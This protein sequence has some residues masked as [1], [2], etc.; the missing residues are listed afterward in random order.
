MEN[1]LS[2]GS[3]MIILFIV[4]C[5]VLVGWSFTIGF[6]GIDRAI[7]AIDS[8]VQPSQA[9]ADE[10]MI[11]I[12]AG[13]SV[14]IGDYTVR[15]KTIR[16]YGR[17]V[18][19]SNGVWVETMT[20]TGCITSIIVQCESS[21]GKSALCPDA[22][23]NTPILIDLESMTPYGGSMGKPSNPS[24]PVTLDTKGRLGRVARLAYVFDLPERVN[25]DQS[26][27]LLLSGG[28]SQTP[29][30]YVFYLQ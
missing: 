1:K 23:L 26:Y 30:T 27:A 19:F 8:V 12:Q 17:Y 16:N 7:P 13:E 9:D 20:S 4:A 15:A 24:T 5:L 28:D 2:F 18:M 25:K 22:L 6:P 3:I 21:T 14:V 11:E 10:G 29:L